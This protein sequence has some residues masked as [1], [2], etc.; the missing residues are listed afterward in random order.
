MTGISRSTGVDLLD[1]GAA[2]EAVA[3]ARPEVVYHLAALAS[4]GRSWEDP[5]RP[6]AE[7]PAATVN[8]LEAVRVQAPEARVLCAGTG[9]VYGPPQRL[10]VTEDAP[11]RPQSPYA[12]SKAASELVAGLYADAHDLRVVRTRAF[13]HAG[14]RQSTVYAVASFARQ[15]AAGIASGAEPIRVVTGNPRS[16][17]DFTDVRCVVRAY[18]MLALEADPGV[19]NVCSGKAVSMAEIVEALGRVA[20]RGV[21]HVVDESLVRRHD[22]AEVR[23]DR[24]RLSAAVGWEPEIPLEQTLADT[25]AWWTG[26]LRSAA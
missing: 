15:V 13:N 7:N 10:P 16:A 23:G 14:P 21:E 8:L 11:L 9:E 18:R 26:E 1:A 6:V 2:R 17:R 20:G 3:G 19:Y 4:V 12:A 25:V 24:G 22:V 5:G